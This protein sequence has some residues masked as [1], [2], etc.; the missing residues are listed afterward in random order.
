MPKIEEFRPIASK[1]LINPTPLT[2][3]GPGEGDKIITLYIHPPLDPLP[4]RE[5][6]EVIGQT[7]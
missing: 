4:S 6:E 1:N 3:E 7:V 5:G 2:G